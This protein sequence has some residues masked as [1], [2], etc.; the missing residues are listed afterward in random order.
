MLHVVNR[1]PSI[2]Q[3]RAEHSVRGTPIP[4]T[5]VGNDYTP[6]DEE[7]VKPALRDAVIGS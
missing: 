5:A 3:Q 6:S 1:G 4:G 2:P 7:N